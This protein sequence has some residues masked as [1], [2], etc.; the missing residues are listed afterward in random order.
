MIESIA[1][2]NGTVTVSNPVSGDHRTFKIHTQPEDSRFAPGRRIVSLLT[3]PDNVSDFTAFGFVGD[4]GRIELWRRNATP[5]FEKLAF[6]LERPDV[7]A[8]KW[9]MSYLWA[10]KCRKCNRKLTTPA[11]VIE[12]IGEKCRLRSKSLI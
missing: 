2:H 6:L 7:A 10:A 9:G 3:G 1:T 4:N 11:S 5:Y 8:Q 12:G